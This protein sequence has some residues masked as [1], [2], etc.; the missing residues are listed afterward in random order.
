MI[1]LVSSTVDGSMSYHPLAMLKTYDYSICSLYQHETVVPSIEDYS[2]LLS[3]AS[4]NSRCFRR[5]QKFFLIY[6]TWGG[7]SGQIHYMRFH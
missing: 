5:I 2:I 1:P 7:V 3:A 6:S 4:E